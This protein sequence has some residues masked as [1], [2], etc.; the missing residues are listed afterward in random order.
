[1]STDQADTVDVVDVPE[2]TTPTPIVDAEAP[3]TDRPTG[4]DVDVSPTVV[5]PSFTEFCPQLRSFILADR[6][7]K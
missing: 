4:E 2:S 5:V 7:W 1:M 6:R 3:S